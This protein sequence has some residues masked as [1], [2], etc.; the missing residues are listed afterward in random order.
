MKMNMFWVIIWAIAEVAFESLPK[1]LARGIA[2]RK[3]SAAA[4]YVKKYVDPSATYVYLAEVNPPAGLLSDHIMNVDPGS[5][6]FYDY[7]GNRI[8][9]AMI[10]EECDFRR[11]SGHRY[12]VIA[13]ANEWKDFGWTSLEHT[14]KECR[15]LNEYLR[16]TRA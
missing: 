3:C 15:E 1:F 13:F 7:Y 4:Q 2:K 14:L 8:P 5:G 12:V 11:H 6:E 16:A 10:G 9:G